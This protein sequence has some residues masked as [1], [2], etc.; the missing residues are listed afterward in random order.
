MSDEAGDS[1]ADRDL[2]SDDKLAAIGAYLEQYPPS[3]FTDRYSAAGWSHIA[4]A[5][6]SAAS[7]FGAP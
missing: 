1:A 6:L 4:R 7:L 5:V 3:G 2:P